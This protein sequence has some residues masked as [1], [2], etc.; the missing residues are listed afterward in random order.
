MKAFFNLLSDIRTSPEAIVSELMREHPDSQEFFLQLAVTYIAA[1]ANR[2][3]Y[4]EDV[5]H[6]VVWS[7]RALNALDGLGG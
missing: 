2:R 1:M 5:A 3:V 7:K 6:I 4:P